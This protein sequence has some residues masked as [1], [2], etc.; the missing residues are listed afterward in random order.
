MMGRSVEVVSLAVADSHWAA[1]LGT[2]GHPVGDL[3]AIVVW[4]RETCR[5]AI[6]VV[7]QGRTS[8]LNGRPPQVL[9]SV[10]T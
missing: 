2:T 1:H 7:L 3:R 8:H 9:A 10:G 6:Q 4:L 5:R